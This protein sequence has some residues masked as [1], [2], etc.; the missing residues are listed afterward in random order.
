MINKNLN[1]LLNTSLMTDH[2]CLGFGFNKTLG[3]GP[4]FNGDSI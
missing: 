2:L 3:V 4:D 1:N